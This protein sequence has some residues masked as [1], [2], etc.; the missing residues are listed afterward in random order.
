MTASRLSPGGRPRRRGGYATLLFILFMTLIGLT[1]VSLTINYGYWALAQRNLQVRSDALALSAVFEVLDEELLQDPLVSSGQADD[2]MDAENTV[3]AYRMF[4]N[5]N[6]SSRLQIEMADVTTTA[7]EVI[8]VNLPPTGMNFNAMS[9]FNTLRVDIER[10]AMG[11][12]PLV[13]LFQYVG[14]PTA[15]TVRARTF[16]TLDSHLVGFAPSGMVPTLAAPIAIHDTAWFVDRP[17]ANLDIDNDDRRELLVQLLA[18][19][20]TGTANA[21]LIDYDQTGMFTPTPGTLADQITMGIFPADLGGSTLIKTD[22][23]PA[24]QLSPA[25]TG[26]DQLVNAFN[27]IQGEIRIFPIYS[28]PFANPTTI[29]GFV[30]AEIISAQNI[31]GGDERL[32]VRIEPAFLLDRT[33]I[34]DPNEPLNTYIHKVRLTH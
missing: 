18:D 34:T 4:S 22:T 7:G 33:A 11:A 31:G 17:A 2:V 6:H 1:A 15:V 8:N 23:V 24:T 27:S 21:V 16:A 12:N 20:G 10:D 25:G 30:A 29:T 5:A 28:G 19:N 13:S 3:E 26:T 14:A 32:Q 9:P